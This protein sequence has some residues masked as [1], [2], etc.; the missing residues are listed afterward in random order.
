[1][2]A[3]FSAPIFSIPRLK[4]VT[5]YMRFDT[6][7][8]V[9]A[10]LCYDPFEVMHARKRSYGYR[11]IT[12]DIDEVTIGVRALL[13]DYAQ[14]HPAVAARMLRNGWVWPHKNEEGDMI[15]PPIRGYNNNFEVVK[16]AAFRRP[17]VKAW[18]D[19]LTS[20]PERWYKYRWGESLSSLRPGVAL[21]TSVDG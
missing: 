21:L 2:C 16:L 6:D 11:T 8:L 7:S 3:F 20:V 4:D 14:A 10:P 9:T 18:L 12:N 17:D 19:E 1:M 13:H 5:Y 15:T